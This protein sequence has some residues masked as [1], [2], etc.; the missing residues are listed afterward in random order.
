[1]KNKPFRK[2]KHWSW[3]SWLFVPGGTASMGILCWFICLNFPMQPTGICE[4]LD[5][6]L[7]SQK[8]PRNII[9][10]RTELDVWR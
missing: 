2:S 4:V 6:P 1:M 7:S 10:L 8:S 3:I 9:S 5:P